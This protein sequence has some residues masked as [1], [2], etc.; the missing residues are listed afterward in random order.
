MH[1]QDVGVD[2]YGFTIVDL[3]NVGHKDDPWVFATSVISSVLHT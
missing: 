3:Q 1:Q 2:D